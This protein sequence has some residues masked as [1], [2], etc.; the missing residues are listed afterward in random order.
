[1]KKNTHSVDAECG[2]RQVRDTHQN[3]KS[4]SP[5][6]FFVNALQLQMK[7]KTST[8][9]LVGDRKQPCVQNMQGAALVGLREVQV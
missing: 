1:M 4:H 6:N 5:W 3:F 9:P 8:P 2:T 7:D